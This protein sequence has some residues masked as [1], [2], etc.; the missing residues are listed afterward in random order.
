MDQGV[1]RER[2]LAEEGAERGRLPVVQQQ[3]AGAVGPLAAEVAEVEGVAVGRVAGGAGGAGFAVRKGEEDLVAFGYGGYGGAC[4]EDY[5]CACLNGG[6]LDWGCFWVAGGAGM[7]RGNEPSWPSTAPGA[8]GRM[9]LAHEMSVWQMPEAWI[10]T[11]ASSGRIE[12]RWTSR[13]SS[14]PLMA[15]RTRAVVVRDMFTN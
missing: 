1:A 7:G 3:G 15:V 12:S 4:F 13:S 6:G 5:S 14:G 10:S 9:P 11:R 2:A 8:H